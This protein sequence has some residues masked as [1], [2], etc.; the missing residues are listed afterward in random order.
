MKDS[1]T[2]IYLILFWRGGEVAYHSGLSLRSQ[3]RILSALARI[4]VTPVANKDSSQGW[5]FSF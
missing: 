5:L 1:I 4:G 3:V 2:Q